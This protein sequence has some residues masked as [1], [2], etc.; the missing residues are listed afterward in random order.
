MNWF[1][2]AAPILE[3]EK[4]SAPHRTLI[5]TIIVAMF[6]RL[7]SLGL[8]PLMDTTE[9]RYAEIARIMVEVDDWVT[10]W[11]D[12]GM[13]FWGK[14]PMSFWFTAASFKLFGIN[15]F[16]ARLPHWLAG[17]FVA[18]LV[19][20]LSA[21]R[22]RREATYAMA[23]LTG[24]VLYFIAAG[25]VM[26]DMALLIGTTLAMR[27]F[28]LG[29]YGNDKDRQRERWLLFI[30]LGIGLLA[31]G[32]IAL[33]LSALPIGLWMMMTGNLATTWRKLPWLR[34]GLV[35]LAI[36][37][38]WYLLAE[39]RTPG[40][41]RYF[42]VGEHWQRFVMPGWQGDLYGSAHEYPHGSI[43]LFLFADLLPWTLL[44]PACVLYG[45]KNRIRCEVSRMDRD[46]QTYLLL[47]GLMPAVF[48]TFAGNILWP[49]VLP[50]FPALALWTSG[51]L[52]R[53][54]DRESVERLL[55]GGVS[56]TVLLTL[57]LVVS[58][59]ITGVSENRSEKALVADYEYHRMPDQNLI[60]LG[61]RPF[62]AAFYSRGKVD[63]VP[64]VAQ[65]I[66]RLEHA[67][68]FVAIENGYVS[69]LTSPLAKRLTPINTHGRYT[70]YVSKR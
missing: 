57:V 58:L 65:L 9:A 28:W 23:L 54:P 51:W 29:L 66:D 18:G 13:P 11:F 16:A 21:R 38:P 27:G 10:P 41:L 53:H 56:F 31:K 32:P 3:H 8:Y 34:G 40:F 45:R 15:E 61:K 43:W 64:N 63:S 26:T 5:Y 25:A 39:S 62:S 24:S 6:A 33:V 2:S 59:P 22:S 49:Y 20:G 46:W 47:W 60:Y 70:L 50:A 44:L 12:Y 37:L 67:S 17:V 52:A 14:P 4:L 42:L 1:R 7:L 68:A 48:F 30:G 69:D 55:T 36:A 35:T 19:W